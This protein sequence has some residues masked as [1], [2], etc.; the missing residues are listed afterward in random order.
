MTV[1][2]E[3]SQV[4]DYETLTDFILFSAINQKKVHHKE[5]HK[6]L[7]N[8]LLKHLW[9]D[10]RYSRVYGIEKV[11]IDKASGRKATKSQLQKAIKTA[12][13]DT[14]KELGL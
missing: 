13:A 8:N 2:R 9:I 1:I 7:H 3:I 10:E 4:K 11:F 5:Y 12:L 6:A 14:E